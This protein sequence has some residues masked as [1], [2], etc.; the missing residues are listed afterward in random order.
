MSYDQDLIFLK[1]IVQILEKL[2][3]NNSKWNRSSVKSP[4][5][6]ITRTSQINT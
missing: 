6:I 5:Q 2:N 4:N 1:K 3:Q